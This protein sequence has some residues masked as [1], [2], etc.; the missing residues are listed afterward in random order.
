MSQHL[1]MT[2][3]FQKYLKKVRRHFTEDDIRD[4]LNEFLRVGFQKGETTLKTVKYG[5]I[6]IR[7]VKLRIR[8]HHAVGRYIVGIINDHEY[9]PVF[10]D[11]K[12]GIYGKNLSFE[13]EKRV[14]DMLEHAFQ[15]VL[16][17]YLEH[18]EAHPRLTRYELG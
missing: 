16:T 11:L 2:R 7:I 3:S 17:D 13:T 10:I 6:T 1:L 9:L 15:Q 12:T 8:V 18:T 14:V 5:V 4:N